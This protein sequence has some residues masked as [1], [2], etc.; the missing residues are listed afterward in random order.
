[1]ILTRHPLDQI[2]VRAEARELLRLAV[3]YGQPTQIGNYIESFCEG[4]VRRH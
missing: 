4:C 2:E 1:M 3:P